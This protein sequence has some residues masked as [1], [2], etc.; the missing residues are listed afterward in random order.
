MQA[1]YTENCFRLLGRQSDPLRDSVLFWSNLQLWERL[2]GLT[3]HTLDSLPKFYKAR[4]LSQFGATTL[5]E[6][7]ELQKHHT[8]T[9]LAA[10]NAL[11][12]N[13]TLP[14]NYESKRILWADR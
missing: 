1:E 11:F 12:A 10:Y 9:V 5:K 8:K 14:S 13:T 3:E 4:V 6:I 7:E 2:L